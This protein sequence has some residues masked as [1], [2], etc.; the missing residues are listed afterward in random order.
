MATA[1]GLLTVA[2]QLSEN[3][4]PGGDGVS[5]QL[6]KVYLLTDF[7]CYT[8][9]HMSVGQLSLL[10]S[11]GR[12][13]STG[14]TCVDAVSYFLQL[15]VSLTYCITVYFRLLACILSCRNKRILIVIDWLKIEGLSLLVLD[16]RVGL[17]VLSWLANHRGTVT[18]MDK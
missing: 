7:V 3:G 16:K 10:A 13:P 4:E 9:T 11:A 14:P 6:S 17:A 15:L 8:H 12:K 5:T 2:Q 1:I 18:P